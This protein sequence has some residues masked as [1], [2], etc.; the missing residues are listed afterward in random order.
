M[1]TLRMCSACFAPAMYLSVAFVMGPLFLSVLSGGTH[2][3]NTFRSSGDGGGRAAFL[4]GMCSR[5]LNTSIQT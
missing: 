5:G 1:M 4:G 3:T 2:L